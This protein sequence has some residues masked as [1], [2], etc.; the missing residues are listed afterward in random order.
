MY[1]VEKEEEEE[2]TVTETNKAERRRV[3]FT[4][5]ESPVKKFMVVGKADMGTDFVGTWAV[6]TKL[7]LGIFRCKLCENAFSLPLSPYLFLSF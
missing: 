7:S 4:P 1:I 5:W 2:E 6:A 3:S